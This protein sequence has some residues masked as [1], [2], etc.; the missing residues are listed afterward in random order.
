MTK[1]QQ[2]QLKR[3]ADVREIIKEC[4]NVAEHLPELQSAFEKWLAENDLD[5]NYARIDAS[6]LY[7][8]LTDNNLLKGDE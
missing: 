6:K 2:M 4:T 5:S 7:E 8:K 1:K 3:F